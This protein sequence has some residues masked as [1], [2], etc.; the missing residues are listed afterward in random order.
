MNLVEGVGCCGAD[1]IVLVLMGETAGVEDTV[2][3]TPF[4]SPAGP[5]EDGRERA[6]DKSGEEL[7]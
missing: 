2:V 7:A 6:D 1:F 4:I 3:T 5:P